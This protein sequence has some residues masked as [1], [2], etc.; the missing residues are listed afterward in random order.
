MR[1]HDIASHVYMALHSVL[2]ICDDGV[3]ITL[4]MDNAGETET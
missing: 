3:N 4:Y 1:K 2:G